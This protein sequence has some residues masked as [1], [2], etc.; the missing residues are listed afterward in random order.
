MLTYISNQHILWALKC[1]TSTIKN[2]VKDKDEKQ[3]TKKKKTK[4][5]KVEIQAPVEQIFSLLQRRSLIS[6]K[7]I[8][9]K[10]KMETKTA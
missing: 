6:R 1:R 9:F 5:L 8:K 10:R 7:C 2:K 4:N 3:E